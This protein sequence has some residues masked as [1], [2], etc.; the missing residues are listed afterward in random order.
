MEFDSEDIEMWE[1]GTLG[2]DPDFAMAGS[3][4]DRKQLD[5]LKEEIKMDNSLFDTMD[6]AVNYE[7]GEGH[8]GQI[9]YTK[10]SLFKRAVDIYQ[11]MDTLKS[12]LKALREDFTYDE[13]VNPEGLPKEDVKEIVSFAAKYVAD[14][15]EK[16]IEQAAVFEALKEELIG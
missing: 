1:N 13:D 5:K 9:I 12:D 3:E 10:E 2:A 11:Q 8:I 7:S 14:S 16:V 6:G 15:V 4:E